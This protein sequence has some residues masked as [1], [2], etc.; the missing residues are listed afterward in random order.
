MTT[1]K[2]RCSG[3]GR[4]LPGG[5]QE[6][7]YRCFECSWTTPADVAHSSGL[8]PTASSAVPPEIYRV[9]EGT[10][11]TALEHIA[12]DADAEAQSKGWL[13]TAQWKVTSHERYGLFGAPG[14]D[15]LFTLRVTYR[16]P[17]S[18]TMSSELRGEGNGLAPTT[19]PRPGRRER[20]ASDEWLMATGFLALITVVPGVAIGVYEHDAVFVGIAAA[21]FAIFYFLSVEPLRKK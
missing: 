18:R 6:S 21:A 13:R 11:L 20:L 2:P 8:V 4:V 15:P 16:Q 3:C 17:G 9:F 10:N 7:G 14:G 12:V 1:T 5:G 19:G